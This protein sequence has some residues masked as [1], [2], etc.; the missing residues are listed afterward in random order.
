M[1]VRR[2]S[3]SLVL[4]MLYSVEKEHE[5]SWRVIDMAVEAL[6]HHQAVVRACTDSGIYRA[7]AIDGADEMHKHFWVPSWGP[8]EPLGAG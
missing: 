5:G 8:P 1:R 7:R 6:D 2:K 4:G 3:S